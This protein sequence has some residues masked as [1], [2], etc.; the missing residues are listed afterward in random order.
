[1]KDSNGDRTGRHWREIADEMTREN[2]PSK[3][4]DLAEQLTRAFDGRKR[5]GDETPPAES[6]HF[7]NKH[8]SDEGA[9]NLF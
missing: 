4:L 2:D 8:E 7:Q 9:E 3:L 5:N 6:S 1:M